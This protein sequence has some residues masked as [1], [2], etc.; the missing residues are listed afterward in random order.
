MVYEPQLPGDFNVHVRFRPCLLLPYLGK[1]VTQALAAQKSQH[2]GYGQ[3]VSEGSNLS[4]TTFSLN[5]PGQIFL[6][7]SI[8]IC[9]AEMMSSPLQ[10][11]WK[12]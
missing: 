9:K 12:D 6:S 3:M 10:D 11:S 2:T 8:L 1:R 7:L 5:G 4:S